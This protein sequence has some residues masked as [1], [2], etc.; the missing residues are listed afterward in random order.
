MQCRSA[1]A[2]SSFGDAGTLPG[3][4]L[5]LRRG[6]LAA[7]PPLGEPSRDDVGGPKG[8][9][10]ER[11]VEEHQSNGVRGAVQ[12]PHDE[13]AAYEGEEDGEAAPLPARRRSEG[14]RGGCRGRTATPLP[15]HALD[16]FL[17]AT[18]CDSAACHERAEPD[19]V[20]SGVSRPVA[21]HRAQHPRASPRCNWSRRT[22]AM[23]TDRRP[24]PGRSPCLWRRASAPSGRVA[25]TPGTRP[26]WS[27]PQA[28]RTQ[29]RYPPP[30]SLAPRPGRLPLPHQSHLIFASAGLAV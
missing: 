12:Q 30:V 7:R 18:T 3:V 22:P 24:R 16:P 2:A 19:R 9:A 14:W 17:S 27:H 21:V 1:A 20:A 5:T 13:G 26:S 25:R 10:E 29:R 11:D 8:D 23:W 6:G 15:T 28:R 4:A